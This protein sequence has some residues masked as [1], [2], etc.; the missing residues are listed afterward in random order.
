MWEIMSQMCEVQ[1]EIWD[2][3]LFYERYYGSDLKTA[4]RNLI[5]SLAAF[6]INFFLWK[7]SAV[8]PR[9]ISF[10][11]DGSLYGPG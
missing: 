7:Y 9:S 6:E 2:I 10:N 11:K 5:E 1:N 3:E 8:N 4:K